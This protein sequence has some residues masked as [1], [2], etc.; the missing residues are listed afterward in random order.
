MYDVKIVNGTIISGVEGEQ[1]WPGCVAVKD[2]RIAALG[3]DISGP[4]RQTLD[5]AGQAVCPGF[6]DLHTHCGIGH[7]LNYLQAGVTTVVT[8]NCG[9]SAKAGEIAVTAAKVAGRSGPNIAYMIGHNTVRLE[10]M[11]NVARAPTSAELDNMTRQV[12]AAM[13]AGA[14]GFSSG[15]T[16][17]PGHY[18]DTA[19]LGHLARAAGDAGGYY[20]THMRDESEGILDSIAEALSIAETGGLPAHIS[21]LKLQ[22]ASVW[23]RSRAVLETLNAARAR[24]RDITWDQYPYTASCG[25][26]QLLLPQWLQE[27]APD[28]VRA[29]CLEPSARARGK[30]ELIAKLRR[31][32]DGDGARILV[33]TSPEPALAG[34]TLADISRAVGRSDSASD[35]AETVLDVV[36]RNPKPY[37]IYCVYHSMSEDD[38]RGILRD[39]V[40]MVASDGWSIVFGQGHPHP[41]QYGTC[42]RV[43]AHYARDEKVLPLPEAV[44]RMTAMPAARLGLAER[45]VLAEGARA[46]LVVFDPTT[47]RDM[48]TFDQPHQYPEGIAWVIVN[49]QTAV[50]HGKPTGRLPGMFVARPSGN[51]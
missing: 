30:E 16:Y 24:G 11:G 26:I 33:A 18:A 38:V 45:G 51:A 1:P 50:D 27:G 46:D 40:T 21:H 28:E 5:A 34:R 14:V 4:A 31:M 25:H 39:P 35:L 47:V 12:A 17:V 37:T 49:G 10:A 19:E 7:N 32:Y 15:L 20:A 9:M 43:L 6:I 23:G 8:G 3:R 42:P 29:R 13:A 44:R 48:A 41:R 2:G 22:G 36:A